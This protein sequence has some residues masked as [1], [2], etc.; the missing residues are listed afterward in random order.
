MC[1]RS[2][3]CA[4][5]AHRYRYASRSLAHTCNRSRSRG[6]HGYRYSG[7][8]T[9]TP[10]VLRLTTCMAQWCMAVSS[11][12]VAAATPSTLAYTARRTMNAIESTTHNAAAKH[13]RRTPQSSR[14][15]RSR[16]LFPPSA[17]QLDCVQTDAEIPPN[18]ESLRAA[19]RMQRW[20][21]RLTSP[22]P[23]RM[24]NMVAAGV[25]HGLR[26]VKTVQRYSAS[27]RQHAVEGRPA[28]RAGAVGGGSGAEPGQLLRRAPQR[29]G[30]QF[31]KRR[32]V[33]HRARVILLRDA[34]RIRGGARHR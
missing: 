5:T 3:A 16:S 32:P 18:L 11:A 6:G 7:G 25:L 26:A 17:S 28:A 24:R 19:K 33:G 21:T 4:C 31:E 10:S 34:L 1:T 22:L 27:R 2:R 15:L 12:A 20:A 14:P 23:V 29:K 8:I 9:D 13:S 30:V